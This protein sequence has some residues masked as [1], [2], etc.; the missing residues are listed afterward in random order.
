MS[1]VCNT[2]RFIYHSLNTVLVVGGSIFW[3]TYIKVTLCD[4]QFYCFET[5]LLLLLLFLLPFLL[6][7]PS[8]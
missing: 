6:T 3:L 5:I 8:F 1:Y 7:D 4:L 2:V